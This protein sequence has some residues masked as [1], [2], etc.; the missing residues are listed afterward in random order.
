MSEF[1]SVLSPFASLLLPRAGGARGLRR[2]WRASTR[3]V[4]GRGFTLIELM[5]V[6]AIVGVV[7]AYAI[8]AYQDYL[9]R[10]RVGEGL[11]L[12]ASA[13]LAVA[14]NAAS[15]SGFSG[16]YVSPPGTRNVESIRVDDD[17]GQIVV[18]FTS[19]V[20]ASGANTLV[21]VPSAPD[22]AE[23]PTARVA[24]SK[25]AV[26]AGAI[27]WECFADGKTSSSLPAPGA[28]P[29]P[30][31]APTLAGKLAPPECRA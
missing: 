28:G 9:A 7:A 2:V 27:T 29:M 24:L 15:G 19:R 30:S 22:Q 18:A 1:L 12:A 23:T 14:E 31:D 16:G 5:I 4:R 6:L 17:T 26:Q 10:S 3:A 25:G 21:L 8:P 20:A 13:R 11:A